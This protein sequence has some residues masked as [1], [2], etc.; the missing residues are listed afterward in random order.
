[1][2]VVKSF[3]AAFSAL[4]LVVALVTVT[5]VP[6]YAAKDRRDCGPAK[7]TAHDCCKAPATIKACCDDRS[8][9]SSQGAPVPAKI[10]VNPNLT[11]AP[12]FFVV[13]L[14]SAA[15]SLVR[16]QSAEN[17]VTVGVEY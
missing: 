10:H 16:P 8:D 4:A 7:S 13:D 2:D 9:T 17:S 11:A 3:R 1:M 14:A 12:A 15:R 5:T 6:A